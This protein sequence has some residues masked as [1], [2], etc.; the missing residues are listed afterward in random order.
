MASQYIQTLFIWVWTKP[1]F[2]TFPFLAILYKKDKYI[3]LLFLFIIIYIK[4]SMNFY[5]ISFSHLI[6]FSNVYLPLYILNTPYN[7]SVNMELNLLMI[8][9]NKISSLYQYHNINNIIT[10]IMNHK[11][12]QNIWLSIS[13]E[14]MS[15]QSYA[16]GLT[17][18][19]IIGIIITF[20]LKI[21][22]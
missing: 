9:R 2:T 17:I 19:T 3:A 20:W 22:V 14:T 13:D 4:K 5:I 8:Q 12:L 16:D 18:N 1:G 21:G 10:I 7:L 6:V 11:H 15:K